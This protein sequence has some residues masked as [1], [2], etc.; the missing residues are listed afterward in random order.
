[1]KT[2]I[3]LVERNQ[4]T[5]ALTESE[6]RYKRLLAAT[7]DYI[8]TVNLGDGKTIHYPGCEGVT[9]Y[10]PASFEKDPFLWYRIIYEDDRPEVLK[11]VDRILKGKATTPLEHRI[12]HRDGSL[13]WIRNTT[14]P[15]Y[16][17]GGGLIGYDGLISNITERKLSEE[18]LERERNLLRTLVDNLPDFI[19]VKDTASRLQMAN[20]A[21]ARALGASDVEAVL[22]KSDADFLPAAL[23]SKHRI[24]EEAVF[25]SKQPQHNVEESLVDSA[26]HQ[27]WFSVTRVPLKDS[28]GAVMGLVGIKHDVTERK[29]AEQ[30][31]RESEERLSLVI[32]GSNDGIWDWNI[33]TGEA[34]FSPRWKNMLGYDDEEIENR[35]SAWE[36]LIHPDD[37]DAVKQ[38]VQS[39][40]AG[41]VPVYE[42]EHRLRH[43]DGTYRWILARGLMQ[44]DANGK[45]IRMAG[46]H[47]DLTALKNATEELKAA[48]KELLET[49]DRLI[50]AARFESMGTLASGVAHEVRNPLQTMLMGVSFLSRKLREPNEDV[51][52]ALKDMEE[53]VTRAD[54]IISELLALSRVTEFQLRSQNLNPIIQKC[55]KLNKAK[56]D[57]S[58]V[59][60]ALNLEPDLPRAQLNA[61]KMEQVFLNLLDNAIQ[62]MPSGGN[63]TVTTRMVVLDRDPAAIPPIF[64]KF[65]AAERLIVADVRDTGTGIDPAILL[66]LFD[67][68]FT[69]K[70][71]GV[72]TGLGLFVVR[73]IIERHGGVIHLD[74][75]PGGGA[76][77][78]I[79][80]KA[81]EEGGL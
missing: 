20:L 38:C 3:L 54:S 45:P 55:L 14:T 78:T 23:A 52:S 70:P 63:L 46:S 39:Y 79:A 1:M 28:H 7:T 64:R 4:A 5:E 77:A 33:A 48:H 69:T 24:E 26:G 17:G 11:Q 41:E 30:K 43:K 21:H 72:G 40:L 58:G 35:L 9:G 8:Y 56:M 25:H 74:N 47:M 49:Q 36:E 76:V 13:R 6:Q 15:H 60:T 71:V 80:L 57:A 10:T 67:P 37:R 12:V 66:R 81:E 59:T 31:I 68:F 62:A 22:G 61:L 2:E 73:M 27:K 19:F 18:A 32:R 53:S 42:L 34:Y 29:E 65:R 75:A 50:Q 44:R 16:N 51:S